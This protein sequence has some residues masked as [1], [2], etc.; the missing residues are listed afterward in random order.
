MDKV[1]A[2]YKGAY[3]KGNQV[4]EMPDGF[5]IMIGSGGGTPKQIMVG[6]DKETGGTLI[7]LTSGAP[8]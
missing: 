6:A 3:G 8:G 4:M 5:M 1:T 2:F 7:T